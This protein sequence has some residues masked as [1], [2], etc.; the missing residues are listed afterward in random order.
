LLARIVQHSVY[1][2]IELEPA[3][4]LTQL[5]P[6]EPVLFAASHTGRF[7]DVTSILLH[8]LSKNWDGIQIITWD[9]FVPDP[10]LRKVLRMLPLDNQFSRKGKSKEDIRRLVAKVRT[11]IDDIQSAL[12]QGKWIIIFPSEICGTGRHENPWKTGASQLAYETVANSGKSMKVVLLG[13][14]YENYTV[15][16]LSQIQIRGEI[17]TITPDIDENTIHRTMVEHEKNLMLWHLDYFPTFEE[18]TPFLTNNVEAE[19]AVLQQQ[20]WNRLLR[21]SPFNMVL[22]RLQ[23]DMIRGYIDT[24]K[25]RLH[26]QN[27]VEAAKTEMTELED[28]LIALLGRGQ[29]VYERAVQAHTILDKQDPASFD[30]LLFDYRRL[31]EQA[32]IPVGGDN[33]SPGFKVATL[34]PILLPLG[35]LVHGVGRIFLLLLPKSK[36]ASFYERENELQFRAQNNFFRSTAGWSSLHLILG[37]IGALSAILIIRLALTEELLIGLG[38]GVLTCLA[39]VTSAVFAYKY[40]WMF[41]LMWLRLT[42]SK[43]LGKIRQCRAAIRAGMIE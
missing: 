37:T 1:V 24:T 23:D 36:I 7:V 42:K 20:K 8:L 11:Q 19:N 41:K 40:G 13:I 3:E 30:T 43:I 4:L 17:L 38:L 18:A 31:C 22:Q 10:E 28:I 2:K 14:N 34:A 12:L 33:V 9:G 21:Y 25:A 35:V 26:Y 16:A 39:S 6:G 32:G 29:S 15:P 5:V 27:I